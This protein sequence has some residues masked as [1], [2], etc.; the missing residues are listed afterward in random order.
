MVFGKR[1]N[2]QRNSVDFRHNARESVTQNITV[3]RA[4]RN[5]DEAM[6]EYLRLPSATSNTSCADAAS[7]GGDG[8]AAACA[9]GL[10]ESEDE[11]SEDVVPNNQGFF[12]FLY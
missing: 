12:K 9:H 3:K 6:V 4:R 10:F 7:L 5:V 2:T 8:A 11:I 1:R